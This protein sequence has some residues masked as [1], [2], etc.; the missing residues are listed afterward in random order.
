MSVAKLVSLYR[1]CDVGVFPYRA[2]GFCKPILDAMACGTPCIVPKLGPCTDFCNEHTS[3]MMP[4]LR[5]QLPV[6][7]RFRFKL[8]FDQQVDRVDFCEVKVETL[9]EYLR[10]AYQASKDDLASKSSE[11]VNVA[12][13]RF[14]WKHSVDCIEKHLEE[15]VESAP[16]RRFQRIRRENEKEHRKFQ[17]A[18]QLSLEHRKKA[19]QAGEEAQ[20]PLT[21]DA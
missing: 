17:A 15:L 2:E 8:G 5:I 11:G 20:R 9:V 7:K 3:F 6:N 10:K 12:R 4:A 18:L 21:L 16:P 14:T 19:A 13:G 1:A